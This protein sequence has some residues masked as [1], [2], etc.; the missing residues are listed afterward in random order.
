MYIEMLIE[1][2]QRSLSGYFFVIPLL[3]LYFLFLKEKGKKQTKGHI[4][5][6]FVFCYYLI[7]ILTMT[8]IG[9]KLGFSPRFEGINFQN[10]TS[11]II[12]N[13]F[14]FMPLG[15]FLPFMYE[16]FNTMKK[17]FL[18]AFFVSL[19]IELFQMFGRGTTSINDL[20]TNTLGACLGYFICKV[21]RKYYKKSF[22]SQKVNDGLEVLFYWVVCFI[23]MISI[24]PII[25]SYLFKLG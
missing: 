3:I 15:I 4:V 10:I 23:I 25:I 13:F 1:T 21:I 9:K 19:S 22:Y 17:V 16:S 11:E 20:I 14:L 5:I 7:G 2:M 8:G 12:L 6:S 18:T 24:Q